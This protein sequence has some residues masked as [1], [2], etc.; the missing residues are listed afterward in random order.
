MVS[1]NIDYWLQVLTPLKPVR[2]PFYQNSKAYLEFSVFFSPMSVQLHGHLRD[3][4]VTRLPRR[5][6]QQFE[7]RVADHRRARKPHPAGLQRL[8]PG[9][10]LWLPDSAGW[11]VAGPL[12]GRWGAVTPHQQLQ[13]PAAGVPGW[14]FHVWPGL[15]HLL[16]QWVKLDNHFI[17]QL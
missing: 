15:Q 4:P 7:L 9:A 5:L 17:L 3:S 10:T 14:P 2:H 11:R 16:Q 13:R 1:S 12:H 6:W 8:R